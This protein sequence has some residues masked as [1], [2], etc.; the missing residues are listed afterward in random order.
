MN[1]EETRTSQT[2]NNRKRKMQKKCRQRRLTVVMTALLCVLSLVVVWRC[3]TIMHGEAQVR[4]YPR[5][6]AEPE[7]AERIVTQQ[8]AEAVIKEEPEFTPEEIE[9]V[10]RICRE[11]PQLVVLVNKEREL[12]ADYDAALRKIC[13]KRLQASD[14]MYTD[15][16]GMLYDAKKAGYSLWIASAYRSRERQQTLVNED[17]YKLMRQ[18]VSEQEALEKTLQETMPAGHSEH[19]TGLA[20]DILS[21]DYLK[22]DEKQE[23]YPGNQWLRE[24]CA[25]YGFILRYPK[26]KVAETQISYEPWHFRY[27]GQE[28]AQFITS[29]HIT[30]ERFVKIAEKGK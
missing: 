9:Q 18:G 14:R 28:A 7:K 24:H 17:V 25:E 29:H 10:Q 3:T 2:R 13:N 8:A 27:V 30:L 26:D 22:L 15:L 16:T 19:E 21:S 6:Q 1:T 20:L 5:L 4:K 11:S 12:S 23:T